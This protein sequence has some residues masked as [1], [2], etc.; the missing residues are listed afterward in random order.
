LPC[1]CNSPSCFGTLPS[2]DTWKLKHV[3]IFT[4]VI[5]YNDMG[6]GPNFSGWYCVY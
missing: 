5:T 4:L 3:G 6:A 2:E 1:Y